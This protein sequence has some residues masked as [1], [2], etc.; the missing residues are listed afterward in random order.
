MDPQTSLRQ[1]DGFNCGVYCC[2]VSICA[3]FNQEAPTSII[4]GF[5]RRSFTVLLGAEVQAMSRDELS[6]HT[7][8][9]PLSKSQ[10]D[11]MEN[12]RAAEKHRVCESVQM[13][14][15]NMRSTFLQAG[16]NFNAYVSVSYIEKAIEELRRNIEKRSECMRQ[17]KARMLSDTKDLEAS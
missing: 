16:L 9:K 6:T 8:F 2:V 14:V 12:I 13:Q 4:P 5:W 3:I 17:M 1:D 11:L 15:R 10:S 7:R